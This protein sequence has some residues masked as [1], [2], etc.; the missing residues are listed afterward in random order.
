MIFKDSGRVQYKITS[1]FSSK[2]YCKS[3]GSQIRTDEYRNQN[4]V[5]L[6]LGDT[7]LLNLKYKMLEIQ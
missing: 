2:V 6:P 5:P 3:W 7:P 1:P 4:P